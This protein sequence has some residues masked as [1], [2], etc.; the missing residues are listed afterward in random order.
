M[1][2]LTKFRPIK[3]THKSISS[4]FYIHGSV[5]C[6]SIL[7]RFNKMQPYAGIYLL[8]NHCLHVSGVHRT[9]H[10][11]YKK[12]V[13]AASGTG[14]IRNGATGFHQRGLIRPRWWKVVAPLR[15]MTCT[16]GCSYS[17]LYS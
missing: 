11:E 5:H 15:N 3:H 17:F 10:Q 9:H 4:F 13:T 12:T 1:L 14:H 6:N 7:I 16:R 8:Q 2:I